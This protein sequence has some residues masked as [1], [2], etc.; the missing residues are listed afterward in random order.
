MHSLYIKKTMIRS[1]VKIHTFLWIF[2]ELKTNTGSGS[3]FPLFY[4]FRRQ[5]NTKNEDVTHTY[6]ASKM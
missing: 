1:G 2:L 4:A 6:I 5:L 3:M